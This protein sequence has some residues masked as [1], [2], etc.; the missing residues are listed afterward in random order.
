MHNTAGLVTSGSCYG[1][2]AAV[3]TPDPFKALA[4]SWK[5]WS[6]IYDDCA[7]ENS[8]SVALCYVQLKAIK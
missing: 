8:L 1:I 4:S 6:K 5:K 2:S 7:G 3:I